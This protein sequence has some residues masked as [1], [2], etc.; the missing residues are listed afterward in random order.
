M[1]SI[2]GENMDRFKK[3]IEL[4]KKF[5]PYNENKKLTVDD[6]YYAY[7]HKLEEED[8]KKEE[9]Q[10]KEQEKQREKIKQTL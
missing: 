2:R 7:L 9:L 4:R 3:Q 10:L 1:K 5:V 8:R 6:K